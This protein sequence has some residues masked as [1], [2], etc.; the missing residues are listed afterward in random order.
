MERDLIDW[1]SDAWKNPDMVAWYHR[2][3]VENRGTSRLKNQVEVDL[4]A[5][6]AVGPKVLDVGIGT[7]RGSLPLA[8]A[9]LEVTGVDSSQAMLEQTGK[10]AADTPMRTPI[11]LLQRDLA[12]LKFAAGEFD[13][14]MSL[15]VLVHFPNWREILAEWRRVTRPGGR[16][17]FDIHSQ[18]HEDA[19]CAAKGLPPRPDDPG[20]DFS[21][22]LSRIRVA[23]LVDTA[24]RLGQ[25]IVAVVPYAGI[26]AGGNINLWLKNTLADGTRHDRTLSWLI[27]DQDL[28]AFALFLEQDV[29][30]HLTTRVTGR[31]MVALDNVPDEAGNQAW[32]ERDERLNAALDKGVDGNLAALVPAFDAGWR[33]RLNQLL[34]HPRNRV[35]LHFLLSAWRDFPGHLDLASFL[36][37]RHADTL[38][39]WRRQDAL[40]QLVTQIPRALAALPEA[41]GILKHQA[42]PLMGGLDY[43]LTRDLLSKTFHAFD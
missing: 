8:Q 43:D 23:D 9:G 33:A 19:A 13:T 5:R 42:V 40:D 29:F 18:D 17:L 2:R 27:S 35:L 10:L 16:I 15:N 20:E 36:D 21:G 37:A 34:D 7:G 11:R 31:M 25:R 26:F 41:A 39:A 28:L 14:V 12:D 3:M 22:Y 30:A 24:N 32:L 4:C 38:A 1:K 6:Y